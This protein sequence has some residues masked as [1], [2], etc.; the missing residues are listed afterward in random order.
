MKKYYFLF[1][2]LLINTP[3]RTQV[4]N[5]WWS[6]GFD[7]MTVNN[8]PD[9]DWI[10]TGNGIILSNFHQDN[11]SLN[12]TGNALSCNLTSVVIIDSILT[13]KMTHHD[14]NYVL[15][16]CNLG[17]RISE[18]NNNTF[19]SQHNLVSGDTAYLIIYKYSGN[20]VVSQTISRKIHSGNQYDN[21]NGGGINFAV[22]FFNL[23]TIHYTDTFRIGIKM[24]NNSHADYWYDFDDFEMSYVTGINDYKNKKS[25]ALFPNPAINEISFQLNSP[26]QNIQIIDIYGKSI[27]F[28]DESNHH[29]HQIHLNSS[30]APGIY[31]I[32]IKTDKE[33]INSKFL[34]E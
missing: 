30:L 3:I 33:T 10:S 29:K 32:S 13:P 6:E 23:P 34:K 27:E 11:A 21:A 22:M 19:V 31:F 5:G 25:I 17:Y 12:P 20:Q 9:N 7:N 4:L 8:M 2:Y 14:D 18:W 26:I 28:R 15:S 1:I 24:I 16:V